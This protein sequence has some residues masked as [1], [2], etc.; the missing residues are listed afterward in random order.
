MIYKIKIHDNSEYQL[1]DKVAY[2]YE[3]AA[4]RATARCGQTAKQK[5]NNKKYDVF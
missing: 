1:G 4:T 3:L 2:I 5:M